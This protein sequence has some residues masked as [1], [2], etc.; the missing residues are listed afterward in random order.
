M[1]LE[2]LGTPT[3]SQQLTN[4]ALKTNDLRGG[5]DIPNRDGFSNSFE[6]IDANHR[7]D[8]PRYGFPERWGLLDDDYFGCSVCAIMTW[9]LKS[10]PHSGRPER[11]EGSRSFRL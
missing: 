3:C 4:A 6:I 7:E 1:Q 11:S 10:T 8:Y 2:T 9:R 5:C